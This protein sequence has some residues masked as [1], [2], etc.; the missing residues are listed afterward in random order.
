MTSFCINYDVIAQGLFSSTSEIRRCTVQWCMLLEKCDVSNVDNFVYS[1]RV[2]DFTPL[3]IFF[4]DPSAKIGNNC[5]IGP[6]VVIGP[7]VVID[8]GE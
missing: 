7:N 4:Q 3:H 6:D 8:D 1:F 2:P 5:R